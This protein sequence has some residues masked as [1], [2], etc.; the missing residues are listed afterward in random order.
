MS[1]LKEIIESLD[2][3]HHAATD[4][5][6]LLAAGRKVK[7]AVIDALNSR[8]IQIVPLLH[9]ANEGKGITQDEIDAL[10]SFAG[11][12]L[13]EVLVGVGAVMQRKPTRTPRKPARK[14]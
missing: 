10:D 11:Q 14:K 4:I 6:L 12:R 5:L 3:R 1:K 2:T 9:K 13:R 8:F 7:P